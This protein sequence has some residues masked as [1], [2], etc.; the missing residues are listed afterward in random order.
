[1]KKKICNQKGQGLV[2]YSLLLVFVALVL[3]V[4]VANS[5]IENSL[6]S[7]WTDVKGCIDARQGCVS[8]K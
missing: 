3:W 7:A 2:E 6:R 5:G 1:M 4:A 8:S